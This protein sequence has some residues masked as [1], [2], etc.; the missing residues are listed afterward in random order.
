MRYSRPDVGH[1]RVA[2]LDI[3]TTHYDPNEGELVSVGVGVHDRGD[4]AETASY[5]TFHRDGSGEAPLVRR[6]LTRLEEYD[7]DV[8]VS[9]NG[10]AFDLDFLAKRLEYLG[11]SVD[12]PTLAAPET[13]VDLFTG[14]KEQGGKWP[15]LEECLEAYGY[16]QAVTT[17][18]GEP[19]TGE[20][21]AR[22]L[23][24]AFLRSLREDPPDAS[25]LESVIDHY[26]R[27]DLEANV[28]VYYAD[29]GVGFEPYL[30]GT[31]AVF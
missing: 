10:T 30:L 6:S 17:W 13:H 3:E 8:L 27:T 25:A 21:F 1:E 28:A 16:P 7:A 22:E 2:T 15:S 31:E 11:E 9:Y 19:V 29:I 14:R 23:G 5:D 26:L 20:R 12:P 18:K 24:P 4:P